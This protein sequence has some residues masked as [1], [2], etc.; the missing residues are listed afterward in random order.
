M[1]EIRKDIDEIR[2]KIER[3]FDRLPPIPPLSTSSPIHLTELGDTISAE[4]GGKE[5]AEAK[6]VGLVERYRGLSAYEIQEKCF[7]YAKRAGVLDD[8]MQGRVLNS[9]YK[10][11]QGRDNV[12]DVLGVELRDI[13][14]RKLQQQTAELP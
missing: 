13:V 2:T 3:I 11:G 5:W 4:V 6:S 8:E 10:H 7:A 12:L 9:A 1:V 14:L